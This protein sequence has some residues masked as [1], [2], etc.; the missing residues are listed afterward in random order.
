MTD[1]VRHAVRELLPVFAARARQVD[2]SGHVPR[3]TI[4]EL[5]SAGVLAMLQPGRYGGAE[6][7]PVEFYRIVREISGVCGSTG[8]LTAVLG[9]HLW[10]L[11][12]FDQRAQDEVWA[13]DSSVLV[14]SAY[15]PTG[16][17][18]PVDGGYELTGHWKFS[19]GCDHPSWA[20]LGGLLF[21]AAGRPVDFMTALVPGADY[22]I[23]DVWDVVGM[24]GTASNGIT[25]DRAFV[26]EHRVVRN[27]ETAQLRG[28]GQKVNTGPLYRLPFA[29]IFTYAVTVPIVGIVAGCYESYLGEMRERVRLS[30]GGG[31]F[32]EDPFAQVAVARA[33]SEV[34]AATLQLERNLGDLWDLARAG[35]ELPTWM[36]LRSRRD[37]VRA[38]ERSLE[39]IDL[40]FKTAGG[41][42]LSRG[43]PIE[44]AWR[45]AHAGSAHVANEPER[46]L[47]LYGRGALGLPVEDNLV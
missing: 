46:A 32:A 24:R 23:H 34:D 33:A 41:N 28:P 13:A 22:S 38:G 8:W 44:R 39:A 6:G 20:L 27:Y 26:P 1:H 47:A 2:E 16:Q 37:Q 9:V 43:N 36:R 17:L 19:S 5:R 3:R 14:S 15:A 11:A 45:D 10:H 25:V 30:L 40:L 42:S 7:D 35:A 31:R 12:L 18:V 4:D 21:G 29:T